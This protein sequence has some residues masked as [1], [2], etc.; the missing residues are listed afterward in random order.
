MGFT[1]RA[2]LKLFDGRRVFL[3]A[4][5]LKIN[6]VLGVKKK[7]SLVLSLHLLSLTSQRES[8]LT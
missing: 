1:F 7:G 2:A 5:A 4:N 3:A 8:S 6:D